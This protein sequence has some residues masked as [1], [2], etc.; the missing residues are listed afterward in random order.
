V[1]D[2][3]D[4]AAVSATL[5]DGAA[6]FGIA[7]APE[8]TTQLLQLSSELSR[9][10]QDFN[11][12]AIDEPREVLTKHLL[13]S[14]SA[15]DELTGPRIAD[16]GTGAGFPGLPLAIV[17]PDRQFL[18][19]DSVAKK[20][21]FVDHVVQLLGLANVRTLHSRVEQAAAAE[22]AQGEFDTVIARAFAPLPRLVQ[23]IAP[24]AGRR[25]RIV[26]M[27][28]RWPPE[29]GAD[30]AASLPAPWRIESVRRVEIPGLEAER[31]LVRLTSAID[32]RS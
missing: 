26:A 13:D 6:H 16:V 4:A 24:L 3:P 31:H 7:L 30:D 28:G 21:R 8:Q 27:K 15:N 2:L 9:W 1:S 17:N 23:F 32:S 10:N 19:I 12:T 18:L 25:T 5:R 14:L 29:P 20:L 11:L 22:R